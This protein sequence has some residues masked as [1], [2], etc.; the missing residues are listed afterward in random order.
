MIFE[1]IAAFILTCLFGYLVGSVPFGLVL[2]RLAGLPD[3]RKIGSGNIGATNVLRTG[4]KDL[5][6]LT[7]IFD[8]GKAGLVAL[9]F[10]DI[11]HS[12]FLGLVAG[13]MA[14]IGHNFPIWLNFKGGKGVASTLGLMV[15]MTPITGWLTAGTWVAMAFFKKYSSLSALTALTLAPIYALFFNSSTA[16]WFYLGLTVLSFYRHRGNI[17][18]LIDGT[19]TKIHLKKET[20][21]KTTKISPKKNIKRNGRRK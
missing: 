10:Q 7:V 17:Q 18:R 6:L 2:T 8:A 3:I 4:R 1:N 12:E 9:L 5:A 20:P 19:E 14:I 16:A 21:S 13:T 11:Y 15:F